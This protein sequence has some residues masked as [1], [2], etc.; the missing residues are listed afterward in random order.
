[1]AYLYF[2]LPFYC[3]RYDV[4]THVGALTFFHDCS[5]DHIVAA[6]RRREANDRLVAATFR[7]GTPPVPTHVPRIS[8]DRDL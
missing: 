1:M 8:A 4:N 7:R 2:Y 6:A 5:A 3:G